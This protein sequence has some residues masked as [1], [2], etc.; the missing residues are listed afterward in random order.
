MV[1][2]LGGKGTP[3]FENLIGFKNPAG[4]APPREVPQPELILQDITGMFFMN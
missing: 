4:N 1:E 3:L 2:E